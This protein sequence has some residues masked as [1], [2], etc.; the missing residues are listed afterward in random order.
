MGNGREKWVR[1]RKIEGHMIH[2]KIIGLQ[3]DFKA[4]SPYTNIFGWKAG[5][6]ALHTY[7]QD[8]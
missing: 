4:T 8:G 5:I 1:G 2:I 7:A 6:N 3:H